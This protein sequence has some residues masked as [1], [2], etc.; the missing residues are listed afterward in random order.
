MW[1]NV[2][3]KRIV[4]VVTIWRSRCPVFWE[5]RRRISSRHHHS[6]REKVNSLWLAFQ[7]AFSVPEEMVTWA[8]RADAFKAFPRFNEAQSVNSKTNHACP[9]LFSQNRFQALLDEII[10][11]E[12]REMEQVRSFSPISQGPAASLSAPRGFQHLTWIC[13]V[14]MSNTMWADG[15]VLAVLFLR[16]GNFHARWQIQSRKIEFVSSYWR[17]PLYQLR[18][19]GRPLSRAV[20]CI[21]KWRQQINVKRHV[22]HHPLTLRLHPGLS[23]INHRFYFLFQQ[24]ASLQEQLDS[25]IEKWPPG[26]S[27]VSSSGSRTHHMRRRRRAF[28]E[29]EGSV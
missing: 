9:S 6:C 17:S 12:E 18:R 15:I 19:S 14:W 8:A 5:R 21:D 2:T 23:G 11:Q 26:C 1:K 27:L 3:W 13:L 28:I 7:V 25:L 20:V 4:L 29:G 22:N 10:Q 24:L 16:A